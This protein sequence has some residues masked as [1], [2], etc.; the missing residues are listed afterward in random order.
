MLSFAVNEGW[1]WHDEKRF[2]F[3]NAAADLRRAMVENP[4][5]RVFFGSGLYDMATPYFASMH[6][7]RHLGRESQIQ[8]NIHEAFYESG[9]MMYLHEPSRKKLRADLVSF[10]GEATGGGGQAASR[11]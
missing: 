2:G 7:A 4:H 10:Y 3:I 8:G 6:T 5:L 1:K 9:H 11:S